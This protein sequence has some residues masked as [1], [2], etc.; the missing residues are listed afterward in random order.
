MLVRD[1]MTPQDS[2]E[3]LEL[4]VA[5]HVV[6]VAHHLEDR[7]VLAVGEDEGALVA[8]GPV[9]G[10]VQTETVLVNE[11]IFGGGLVVKLAVVPGQLVRLIGALA[12][13]TFSFTVKV[14]KLVTALPQVPL[15]TTA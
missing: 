1:V 10:L 15:T 4:V 13:N 7:H 12:T 8:G 11:L 6:A 14:A 9:K 2:L 3:V 5:D